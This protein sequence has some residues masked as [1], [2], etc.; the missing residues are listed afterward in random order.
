MRREEHVADGPRWRVILEARWRDRLQEV[1]ELSLAY[2]VAVGDAPDGSAD[3]RA[4]R[5]VRRTVAARQRLADTEDAL[6][7]LAAGNFGECEQ[8]G[9]PIPGVVLFAAPESRY[10]PG[11]AGAALRTDAR[12]RVH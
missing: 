4:R 3:K 8:C 7:R 2:H 12:E 10:C 5:L 6:N 1:T 9:A 11:C